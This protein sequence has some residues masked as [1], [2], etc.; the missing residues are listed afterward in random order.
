MKHIAVYF[1][2]MVSLCS[3]VNA[4]HGPRGTAEATVGGKKVT[5]E[6]GRAE[7]KGRTIDSLIAQLPA[8]RVWRTGANELTTLTTAGPLSVGGKNVPAGTYSV[9]VYAPQTGD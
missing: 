5:V 3:V 9:Y 2:V 1:V 6:Y 4:Q 7:L 8:D